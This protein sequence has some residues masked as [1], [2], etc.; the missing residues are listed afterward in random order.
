MAIGSHLGSELC[1]TL[2][3]LCKC[4]LHCTS[5]MHLI[6]FSNISVC[7]SRL[8]GCCFSQRGALINGIKTRRTWC[9]SM[10][11][12]FQCLAT[13]VLPLLANVWMFP[14]RV[15][16]I[17]V[18]EPHLILWLCF[19]LIDHLSFWSKLL[20]LFEEGNFQNK[21]VVSSSNFIVMIS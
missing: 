12:L 17:L 18:E 4:N 16:L 19:G 13:K 14:G 15:W 2:F 1:R 7:Q 10:I 21:Q 8:L 6:P 3:H 9:P 5:Q 20:F 11:L